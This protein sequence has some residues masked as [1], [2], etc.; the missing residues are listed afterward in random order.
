MELWKVFCEKRTEVEL[1]MMVTKYKLNE[2]EEGALRDYIWSLAGLMKT[3][4]K[5]EF[6]EMAEDNR[7]TLNQEVEFG[8]FL[9]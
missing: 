6:S 3:I 9:C 7:F 2:E 8:R 1:R 5:D 4:R